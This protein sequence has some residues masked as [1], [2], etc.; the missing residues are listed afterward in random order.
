LDPMC[1]RFVFVLWVLFATGAL[2]AGA[3]T[4]LKSSPAPAVR[5]IKLEPE[6]ITLEDGRDT[7]KVLVFGETDAKARIDLTSGAVL[8]SDSPNIEID[9][10]GYIHGRSKGQASVTIFAAGREARLLV[11]VESAAVPEVR[12]VRDIEPLLSKAGCNA[13]TCHGS[14]KGKNGFKLSLRGYDPDFDYQALVNDLSG[15]RINRVKVEESLMLLKPL[16]EVPHEGRQA[17]KP[18]SREYEVLR[19][20]IAQGAK[21]ED[22]ATARADRVEILPAEVNLTLPGVA[23]QILVLA[24][25]PDGKTRDVTREAVVTSNNPDVTG[26]TNGVVT[27]IRRGEAAILVRYEGNYATREVTVMGDRT[28]YK[29]A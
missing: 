13:G 23:Q 22:P 12:F 17:I 5:K 24:H 8:K 26:I 1:C 11:K 20:W 9:S 18:G 10:E 28:G 4:Q 16:A 6:S 3:A 25:Y 21:F 27:A 14:A 15:R 2:R 19:Q 7:R 29:W